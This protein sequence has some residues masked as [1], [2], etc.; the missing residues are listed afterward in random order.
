M[1]N[2]IL[3]FLF[4]LSAPITISTISAS[5]IANE[6]TKGQNPP[7]NEQEKVEKNNSNIQKETEI[8]NSEDNSQETD[9]YID[10]NLEE[11]KEVP[12]PVY[13]IQEFTYKF[14]RTAWDTD[15]KKADFVKEMQKVSTNFNE[16][17]KDLNM[18][19]LLSKF[20]IKS[21]EDVPYKGTKDN[22]A[23]L[24]YVPI[25]IT[26]QYNDGEKVEITE[27]SKHKI[28][29][30]YIFKDEKA[31]E[32]LEKKLTAKQKNAKKTL[33]NIRKQLLK[34]LFVQRTS[35]KGELM[36]ELKLIKDTK[37]VE[38]YSDFVYAVTGLFLTIDYLL[39]HHI[40]NSHINLLLQGQQILNSKGTPSEELT[41]RFFATQFSRYPYKF[42]L[43]PH[44]FAFTQSYLIFQNNI[45]LEEQMD[46]K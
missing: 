18:L 15:I 38:K 46:N 27:S 19:K 12:F 35:N 26:I 29:Y 31:E 33:L 40:F 43:A 23:V 4:I 6:D 24:L 2:K 1:K 36:Y 41:K 25:D 5:C 34:S 22:L 9:Q 8:L 10:Q 20:Y 16:T 13:Q 39:K 17:I 3:K 42:N 21:T 44:A 14:P 30:T 7:K 32:E 28:P 11:T 45:L 37:D